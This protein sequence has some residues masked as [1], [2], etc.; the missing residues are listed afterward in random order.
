MQLATNDAVS[1]VPTAVFDFGTIEIGPSVADSVVVTV[2]ARLPYTTLFR[3]TIAVSVL[4]TAPTVTGGSVATNED[5]SVAGAV[6]F[7]PGETDDG[8]DGVT[9]LHTGEL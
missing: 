8:G 3:S 6:T 7:A 4:D 5:H 2:T 1:C 9:L